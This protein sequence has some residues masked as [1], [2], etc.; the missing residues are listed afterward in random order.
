M[1]ARVFKISRDEQGQRLT[2]VKVTGGCVRIKMPLTGGSGD[3]AW[4]E[5]VDQIRIYAGPRYKNVREAGPGMICA[6]T[7]LTRTYAGEGWERK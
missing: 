2:W 7:G 4:E 6:L 3:G 5:K 1:G